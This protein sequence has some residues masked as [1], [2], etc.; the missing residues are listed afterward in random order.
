MVTCVSDFR[1]FIKLRSQFM[2]VIIFLSN[3]QSIVKADFL[4]IFQWLADYI[5]G[6]QKNGGSLQLPFPDGNR[7]GRNGDYCR[8]S[9]SLNLAKYGNL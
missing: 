2:R 6:Y 4:L 8:I 7:A 1:Q 3:I 9:N 5:N